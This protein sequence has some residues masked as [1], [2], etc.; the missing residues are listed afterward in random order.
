M[1]KLWIVIGLLLVCGTAH[2]AELLVKA[3]PHWMDD[4]KQSD[5]DKM[6]EGDK[7]SYEARSQI[8]DVIVVKPD[9]W[10]WG[11]EECLPNFIVIKIP[12]LKY[13]DAKNYEQSLT[14]EYVDPETQMIETRMLK[15]RKYQIPTAVIDDA[16]QSV[17]TTVSIS[18]E[19]KDT[20]ISNVIEKTK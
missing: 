5:I 19:Q 14:E 2:G 6:S 15:C 16:K 10:N 13:E 7:Q 3:K 1:R 20:F 17:S 8:G 4:L 11:K 9:G 18:K 12:D